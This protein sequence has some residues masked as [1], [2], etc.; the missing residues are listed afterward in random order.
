[1]NLALA[2]IAPA[3]ILGCAALITAAL[4][5]VSASLRHML[6]TVAIFAA[7]LVPFASAILPVWQIPLLMESSM[8]VPLPASPPRA[9]AT[10]WLSG[11]GPASRSA[12]PASVGLTVGSHSRSAVLQGVAF[13]WLAGFAAALS[14]FLFG[15]RTVRGFAKRSGVANARDWSTVLNRLRSQLSIGTCVSV[16]IGK[17]SFPP[18]TWGSR[19]LLP[20]EA[21][22]WSDEQRLSVL[23]H[24]LAHV[25]RHDGLLQTLVQSICAVY[26]FNPFFW[27][28]ASRL[29]LERERACDD[30]V[31]NLGV[32]AHRYASHLLEVARLIRPKSLSLATVDMAH[33]SQLETRIRD[34]VD[35][36]KC[37]RPHTRRAAIASGGFAALLIFVIAVV[38]VNAFSIPV[39]VLSPPPAPLVEQTVPPEVLAYR[40]PPDPGTNVQFEFVDPGSTKEYQLSAVAAPKWVGTWKLNKDQSTVGNDA[41]LTGLFRSIESVTIQLE[42]VPGGITVTSNIVMSRSKVQTQFTATFGEMIRIREIAP[43]IEQGGMLVVHPIADS[44]LELLLSIGSGTAV[45]GDIRRVETATFVVSADGRTLTE[46]VSSMPGVRAVFE[47]Q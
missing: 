18:M 34:I 47:K 28:A 20:V 16:A 43:F 10:V 15:I 4:T 27:F 39:P 6:W 31:L 11:S 30:Q 24:E 26:W 40:Y 41:G 3:I 38:R 12:A 9:S 32:D 25:R 22:S 29:R 17:E 21:H 1:M 35:D 5:R 13:V 37:R 2:V 23:A 19:I 8:V 46:T 14:R 42:A 33:A 45:A 44:G 36:R 7:A